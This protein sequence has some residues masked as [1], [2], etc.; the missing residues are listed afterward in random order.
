MKTDTKTKKNLN[1][2]TTINIL[3]VLSQLDSVIKPL[4][5]RDDFLC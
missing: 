4:I 5:S 3:L 1:M 2:N